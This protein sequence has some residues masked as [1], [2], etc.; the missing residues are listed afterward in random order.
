MKVT[1]RLNKPAIKVESAH[2]KLVR[3]QIGKIKLGGL[4]PGRWRTL[5]EPEI[6]SLL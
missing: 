2:G 1:G 6:K 4:R 3:V 5:T